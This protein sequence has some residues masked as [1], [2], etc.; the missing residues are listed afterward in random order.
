MTFHHRGHFNMSEKTEGFL[1]HLK[2]MLGNDVR[3]DRVYEIF[4][5]SVKRF[6]GKEAE[7]F[8]TKDKNGKRL[9]EIDS[10]DEWKIIDQGILL[11]ALS[12]R[13]VIKEFS[14]SELSQNM[15]YDSDIH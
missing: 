14:I 3:L 15:D 2:S 10:Y 5:P 6:A 8:A 4:G 1:N 9:F 11:V 7:A 12:L 13:G